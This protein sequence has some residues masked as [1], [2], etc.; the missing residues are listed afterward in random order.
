MMGSGRKD[1]K[2]VHAV[3]ITRPFCLGQFEIT[4]RQWEQVMSGDP[5]PP[6]KSTDNLPKTYVS[7]EEA[8]EFVSKINGPVGKLRFRL[9]TEA[10]WEY[11]ARAG[12]TWH[13]SFGD[14]PSEL[15]R[16]GNCG[17]KKAPV[18]QFLPNPWH[19]YDMHGNLWEWVEDRYGDYSAELAI[20]PHGPAQGER[21]VRRGG[22][23]ES[24]NDNCQSTA[25]KSAEPEK[26]L[27][28]VGFRIV[29][30]LDK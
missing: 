16:Y 1:E 7:W 11:A 26:R 18:G 13:Y 12:T 15:S 29:E 20:D 22:G 23:F 6:Q 24:S 5:K 9:P 30:I 25:R 4:E 27:R 2:P 3:E 17:S 14:D 28:N 19:L 10:E 21:R 8:E